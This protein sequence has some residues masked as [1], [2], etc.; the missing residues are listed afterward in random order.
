MYRNSATSDY[1]GHRVKRTGRINTGVAVYWK[2]MND[3]RTVQK[4]GFFTG[5]TDVRFQLL[6]PAHATTQAT[7][8]RGN[9]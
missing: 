2:S 5:V 9:R 4:L 6:F 3:G 8:D 1:T 7:R